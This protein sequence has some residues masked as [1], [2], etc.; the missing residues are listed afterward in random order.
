MGKQ[1]TAI[2]LP[3]AYRHDSLLHCLE[4]LFE[5]TPPSAVDVYV[6]IFKDDACSREVLRRFKVT[7]VYRTTDEYAL[8]CIYGQNVLLRAAPDYDFYVI[9]SDDLRY[10]AGW[11]EAAW[12]KMHLLHDYGLV[13]FN[14]LH[15]DG[16]E[17]AAHFLVS[18]QFLIDHHG[19]VIFPP[20]YR[21]WW[22]DRELSDIAMRH[23]CYSFATEAVV[24]HLNHAWGGLAHDRT[25]QDAELNYDNDYAIYQSLKARNFPVEWDAIL[26]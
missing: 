18:R 1:K 12:A 15:S 24:E 16:Y 21:S 14:D 13:G 26:R 22:C 23:N 3:S 2:L 19:G 11:F 20:Q 10:H 6:S 8:G 25:Y 9:A 4:S 7:P 5:H 17:Y